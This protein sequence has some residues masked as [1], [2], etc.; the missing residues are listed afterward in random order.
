MCTTP[1]GKSK[2]HVSCLYLEGKTIKPTNL[3]LD[4]NYA[5]SQAPSNLTNRLVGS[6]GD[7]RTVATALMN[8]HYYFIQFHFQSS[9]NMVHYC[10]G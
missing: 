4:A 9:Q 8:V 6:E 2:C 1:I 5:I 10:Y 3:K 7:S